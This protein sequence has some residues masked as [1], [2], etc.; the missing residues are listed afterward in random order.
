MSPRSAVV[1]GIDTGGTFT[2]FV[3][4]DGMHPEHAGRRPGIR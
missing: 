4:V 3:V 2:D 1:V